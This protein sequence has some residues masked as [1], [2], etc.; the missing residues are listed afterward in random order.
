MENKHTPG[1]WSIG[2]TP[3]TYEEALVAKSGA[4]V[5][6]AAWDGGSGC[7]LKIENPSDARLIAAAPDLLEALDALERQCVALY[8]AATPGGNYGAN[9]AD[10]ERNEN[11][12]ADSDDIVLRA[13]AAIAKARGET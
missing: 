11:A 2:Q 6:Y 5:S 8:R 13:R 10:S 3:H 4:V 7:H 12:F 9:T 1:P